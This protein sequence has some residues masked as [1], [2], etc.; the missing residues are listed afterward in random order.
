M[1]GPYSDQKFDSI[2]YG[3]FIYTR[4]IKEVVAYAAKHI[5]I[6]PEIEMPGHQ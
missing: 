2:R 6:V 3:G 4:T 1:V 5:T